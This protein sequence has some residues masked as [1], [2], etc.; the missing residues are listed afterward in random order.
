MT[1]QTFRIYCPDHGETEADARS[2]EAID[3]AHA[4][5]DFHKGQNHYCGDFAN[6]LRVVVVG[7]G[8]FV[9]YAEHTIRYRAMET[10]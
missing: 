2:I 4:V 7:H 10:T 1:K 3:A 8:K 6:E 9:S 5:I